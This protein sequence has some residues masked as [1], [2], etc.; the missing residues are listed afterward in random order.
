MVKTAKKFYRDKE[1]GKLGGIC[2]GIANYFGWEVWLV[3]I[4]ALT[5]LIFF[6]AFSLVVYIVTW[7]L[8]DKAPAAS[9]SEGRVLEESTKYEYTRDGRKVEVKTRVWEAGEAPKDALRDING[10]FEHMEHSLRAMERYVTS[11]EFKVR[12]EFNR[13]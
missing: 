8:A 9:Q 7:F 4:I 13:L 12:Q 3:R 5:S 11:S 6:T 2:A 1:R 10:Q